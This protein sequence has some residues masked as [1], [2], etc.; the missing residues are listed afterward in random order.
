MQKWLKVLEGVKAI[1]ALAT[2]HVVV[3]CDNANVIKEE[4]F[5][6]GFCHVGHKRFIKY[7]SRL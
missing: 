1:I 6:I 4:K 7:A 2:T 5:P 3:E